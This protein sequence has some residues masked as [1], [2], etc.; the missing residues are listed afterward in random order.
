MRITLKTITFKQSLALFAIVMLNS[1]MATAQVKDHQQ[2]TAARDNSRSIA[3]M[4]PEF[5]YLAASQAIESGNPS[6]AIGFLKA[7]TEKDQQAVLPRLQLAELLLQSGRAG[8]ARKHIKALLAMPDVAAEY[9]NKVQLLD[10]R[11]L[12]LDGK[13]DKAIS[14]LQN[15]LHDTPAAYPLRLMLV[16]LLTREKR[17]AEAHRSIQNGL[18]LRL[19]PQLYHIDAQLYIQQGKLGKAEKSLKSLIKIEPDAVGPV[20]MYSQLVLRQKKPIKAENLLRHFLVRHPESLSVSNALGRLLV[21]QGRSKE[22]TR[23]Y[24]DIAERSGGNPDVLI[25]LGLLHFQQQSFAKAA[26]SFRKALKQRKDARATFYLAASVESLGDKDTARELYSSLKKG[27]ENF[28][29]AQLRMAALDL[30]ANRND[31]AIKSLHNIIHDKPNAGKAYALLSAALMRKKAFKQLIEETEP[32]LALSKVPTQLLF[33]RAAA[34]EGLKQFSQAAG[35]IKQLFSIDPNNIEALNF[36]GY[37]Y[38][39]QGI[40]LDEAEK[41]IRRALDKRPDNGYYLDSLAWVHFK[42]SEY[43][44]ALL[45]QRKAVDI[46]P[47]DPIMREH[48]GDI[49]W[50]SGKTDEARSAWKKAVQLGHDS[51]HL[52]Q[53]KIAQGM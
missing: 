43:T 41:L 9:R 44:K 35:Q 49:L 19:H 31:A 12:V 38:A 34:F 24:E 22:A 8:E 47:D 27:D 17:F 3:H 5:L 20:L 4:D 40:R 46:V 30:L 50:K 13:Q 16:R 37:L 21:D 29:A 45:V 23:V 6:L 2:N 18:K 10:V 11:M 52:M 33:N 53:Q 15:M 48:L 25:A 32:A 1:C 39:E 36:L 51:S 26:A 42:R 14:K 28:T 7:L